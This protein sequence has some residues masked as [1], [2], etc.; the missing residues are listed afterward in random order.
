MNNFNDD[1]NG[2]IITH[3]PLRRDDAGQK[4]F[5]TIIDALIKRGAEGIVLGCTEIPILIKQEDSSVP[6]F[7]TT[8]IHACAAIEFALNYFF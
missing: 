1:G 5:I 4:R 8:N 7:D 3:R 2:Q 6:V